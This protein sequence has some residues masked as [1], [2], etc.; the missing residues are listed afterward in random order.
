[1]IVSLRP[2]AVALACVAVVVPAS[3]SQGHPMAGPA[4]KE[5]TGSLKVHVVAPAGVQVRVRVKGPRFREVVRIGARATL[6]GLRPG[7]YTVR[8]A[9]LGVGGATYAPTRRAWKVRVG[10]SQRARVTVR[11]AER[12]GAPQQP[13]APSV[14]PESPAPA[15]LIADVLTRINE[16]RA[17]GVRCDGSTGPA[18]AAISYS[19]ELGELARWHADDLAA[20][21][22]N[23]FLADLARSGFAG[24][25]DGESAVRCPKVAGPDD[26]FIAMR[27][28]GPSCSRLFDPTVDRIGIAYAD[29]GETTNA[30]V[31][32]LGRSS[33]G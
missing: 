26:V 17:R 5:R 21:R 14:A 20:G 25:F 9:T 15:G 23:D 2:G 33:S 11:Y 8:A 27:D 18:L 22:D 3:R 6:R 12:I 19:A 24:A 10:P 32:T 29:D 28:W 4:V 31:L 16:A 13:E 1:M 30:W 7:E